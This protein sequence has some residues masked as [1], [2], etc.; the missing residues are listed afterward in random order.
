M[1]KV[2][3]YQPSETLRPAFRQGVDVRA[4]PEAFGA[5]IGQGLQRGG[6]ALNTAAEALQAVQAFDNENHA[7]DT[8]TAYSDWLRDRAHGDGGYFSTEGKNAVDG[9]KTF[10]D[11]AEAKRKEFGADLKP[12]ASRLYEQASR[13]LTRSTLEQAINHQEQGRKSYF[14]Q[15]SDA[16]RTGFANNALASYTDPKVV[17]TN[18]AAGLANLDNR[19]SMEGWGADELARQKGIFTSGVHAGVATRMMDANPIAADQYVKA[20][21]DDMLPADV[22]KLQGQLEAPLRT[23]RTDQWLQD[24]IGSVPAPTASTG[25]AGPRPAN[26]V[27]AMLPITVHTESRGNPNAVSPKGARGLMQVMPTT[28]TDPGFGIRPSNGTPE[29]VVRVGRD[30]LGKMM[31]RYNNDPAKAWAAYNAG[32]GRLDKAVSENGGNWLANMPAETRGYVAK[33]M[34]ALGQ[35]GPTSSGDN[36]GAILSGLYAKAEAIKN[37]EDRQAAYEAVDRYYNRQQRVLNA[38]RQQVVDDIEKRMIADPSF[39]PKTLT[40]AT[41]QVIGL[42]G[43]SAL[44]GSHDA[45]IRDGK[46]VTDLAT[47]DALLQES[48]FD[49]AGFAKKDLLPYRGKLSDSDYMELRGKQRDAVADVGKAMRDGSIYRDAFTVSKDFY[50]A[51]GIKTSGSA[52]S[53]PPN[54]QRE[55]QF[56]GA[57]RQEVDDFVAREKRKPTYDEM[58]GIASALTLKVIGSETRGG[59]SPMRM[60]DDGQ[61]DV[62]S[63]RAF[64]RGDIPKGANVRP[65]VAIS[66]VPAEWVGPLRQSLQRR[67]GKPPKDA[68]IAKEWGSVAM[69]LIGR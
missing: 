8:T 17:G 16:E 35:G 1:P 53:A 61:D 39:D 7:R 51:A 9:Y 57:M 11:E 41:Q 6:I 19:G 5:A 27:E 13:S 66:D 26:M 45:K 69:G 60:F 58:R 59:W 46:V 68:D 42:S 22:V 34:K 54:K 32:P 48:A 37:P 10:Q 14:R 52:A 62:W 38:S 4:T 36:S 31:E 50:D 40:V 30:Y 18:L 65:D 43:M 23:A 25:G 2:P 63:G 33:N 29:D 56:N 12:S 3:E 28:M 21:T 67:T 24:A 15:S 64:Q 44:Q 20:H 55:A 49:P 47:K